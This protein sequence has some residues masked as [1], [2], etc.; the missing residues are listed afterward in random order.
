M[1]YLFFVIIKIEAAL[2]LNKINLCCLQHGLCICEIKCSF[3]NKGL[4]SPNMG[5][6]KGQC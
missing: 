1:H 4:L 2:I 6:K 3:L 5:S